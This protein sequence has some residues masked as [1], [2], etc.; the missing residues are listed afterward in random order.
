MRDNS[1]LADYYLEVVKD[2]D[3][4][5]WP[6]PEVDLIV[7]SRDLGA[8][9]TQFWAYPVES[10]K[11]ADD[12]PPA[13]ELAREHH[14]PKPAILIDQTGDSLELILIKDAHAWAHSVSSLENLEDNISSMLDFAEQ[15]FNFKVEHFMTTGKVSG[16]AEEKLND[17][18]NSAGG[19]LDD[20]SSSDSEPAEALAEESEH[21]AWSIRKVQSGGRG[22]IGLGGSRK[23]APAQ[24]TS[25]GKPF[26]LIL[27]LVVVGATLAGLFL[28]REKLLAKLAD[29]SQPLNPQAAA[30]PTPAPLPTAT[31]T[32][33]IDRSALKVR[34]LN[35]TTK[36]GAAADLAA[37][38][39]SLGWQVPETGN[40]PKKGVAQTQVRV[41]EGM[42]QVGDALVSDLASDYTAS[43]SADLKASDKVDAEVV[44]GLK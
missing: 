25:R 17:L 13:E 30:S 12:P 14:Q 15:K 42:E 32:P 31:P 40:A 27:V 6:V 24:N 21:D 2:S 28:N 4:P 43:T 34:V 44:I 8:G 9:Y 37:N 23:P 3:E 35:G 5:K 26:L 18:E 22:G 36:T 19:E 39:K 7:G 33:A 41:K 29:R 11:D 16:E 1:R 38:L 10:G 20:E